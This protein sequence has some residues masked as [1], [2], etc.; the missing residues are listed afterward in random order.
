MT[1]SVCTDCEHQ[2]I[3]SQLLAGLKHKYRETN[4]SSVSKATE[5]ISVT[6]LDGVCALLP[7]GREVDFSLGVWGVGGVAGQHGR[8]CGGG[9]LLEGG[10]ESSTLER[11]GRTEVL[12]HWSVILL[13][14]VELQAAEFGHL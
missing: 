7:A 2:I 12:L 3:V 10:A 1:T 9:A 6:R 4:L 11:L 13:F 8:G 5:L 14:F